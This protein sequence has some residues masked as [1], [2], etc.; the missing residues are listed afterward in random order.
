MAD[1]FKLPDG[2]PDRGPK[3]IKV[4]SLTGGGYRGLYTARV[5]AGLEAALD[6][7]AKPDKVKPIGERFDLIVGTSIGGILACALSLGTP[8]TKLVNLLRDQGPKIFPSMRFRGLRK[9]FG[10]A[11][12][13]PNDLKTAIESCLGSAK[14]RLK[15][16]DHGKPLVL[17]TVDWTTSTLKLLGSKDS[18]V[19]DTLGLTLLDAM[20]ATSAAP[21]HF[22]THAARKHH[23]V[24]GGLAA[25]APDM[26]ALQLAQNLWPGSDVRLLSIGTANPLAGRD[27]DKLPSR[28]IGWAKPAVELCMHAQE[29][30]A[31]DH[32]SRVL[33]PDRYL[34]L[35]NHP[36]ESQAAKVSLD[37]A[38]ESSTKI[39]LS[40]ADET[41]NH[42]LGN[43]HRARLMAML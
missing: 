24:D 10:R 29:S 2:V 3:Q 43:Q 6:P 4:L 38:T 1:Q 35:N 19:R 13:D 11:P 5:L 27:P 41:L 37:L 33:G 23:F 20:L 26:L 39:L 42:H 21:M 22:P 17:T 18:G 25:N 32:C 7:Q 15:L 36:S 14:P 40:L 31:V 8:A 12:Y 30:T 9:L 16:S 34:R 28:G